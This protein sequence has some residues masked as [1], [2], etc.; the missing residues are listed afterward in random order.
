M[1]DAAPPY[2]MDVDLAQEVERVVSWLTAG[3]QLADIGKLQ[4]DDRRAAVIDAM[5]H[6]PEFDLPY[7]HAD[8]T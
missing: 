8:A 5:L 2:Q 3:Q 7:L 1:V 4:L 6:P